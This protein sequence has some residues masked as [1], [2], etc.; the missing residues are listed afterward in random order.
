MVIVTTIN[1]N[2]MDWQIGLRHISQRANKI[3]DSGQWSDCSFI[4]GI[5]NNQEA[6]FKYY[7]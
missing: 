3:L 4:V 6:S 1:N 5:E 2:N 7:S